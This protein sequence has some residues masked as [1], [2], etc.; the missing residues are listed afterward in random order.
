MK[1]INKVLE[2]SQWAGVFNTVTEF[3]KMF[4][5]FV[6]RERDRA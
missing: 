4:Y 2:Q 1:K 3:L 5:L 6:F